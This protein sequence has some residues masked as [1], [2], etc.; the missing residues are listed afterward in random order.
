LL[1]KMLA[2][3]VR[4]SKPDLGFKFSLIAKKRL[5]SKKKL[6]SYLCMLK[7]EKIELI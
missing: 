7:K 5:K 6:M 4:K 3:T 2:K 1:K